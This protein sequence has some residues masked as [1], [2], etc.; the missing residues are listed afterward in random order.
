[1]TQAL[2]TNNAVGIL[3]APITTGS[4]SLTVQAGQGALFPLPIVANN[5]NFWATLVDALT[6]TILEIVLVTARSADTFTIVR[7]QQGTTAKPYAT[8]DSIQLRPTATGLDAMLLRPVVSVPSAST[9]DI[10]GMSGQ[11]PS[12]TGVVPVTAW[13]MLSG[14]KARVN[15]TAATPITYNAVTNQIQGGSSITGESGSYLE[16]FFDGTTTFVTYILVNGAA[17]SGPSYTSVPTPIV[18]TGAVL[19][20]RAV[21]VPTKVNSATATNTTMMAVSSL[22]D[23]QS[24]TLNN[25]GAGVATFTM[26]GSDTIS[27]NN[28]NASATIVLNQGETVTLARDSSTTLLVTASNVNFFAAKTAVTPT[29]SG[30]AVSVNIPVACSQFDLSLLGVSLNAVSSPLLRYGV[31]GGPA[32]TGYINVAWDG[33]GAGTSQVPTN[34]I[35]L[36]SVATMAAA[37]IL[38]GTLH[39]VRVSGNTWNVTGG[40]FDSA[41]QADPVYITGSITL[42]GPLT[43]MSITSA[44]G[45]AVFDGGSINATGFA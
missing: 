32:I 14:Q 6:E 2:Y 10:S 44:A 28:L 41:F 21:G 29:T 45:T 34:G 35:P 26:T 1:M 38:Y 13:T 15:F 4:T 42:S 12:L 43:T 24:F 33:S 9:V 7:A 16:L 5:T 19:T 3:T 20:N 37:S 22:I 27:G 31:A 30:T 8:G 39:F 11:T 36:C 18:A 23:G 40:I 25:V 17:A